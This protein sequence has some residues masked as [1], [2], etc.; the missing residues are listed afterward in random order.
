MEMGNTAEEK[1]SERYPCMRGRI[2]I[3]ARK[4][5]M[6]ERAVIAEALVEGLRADGEHEQNGAPVAQQAHRQLESS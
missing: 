4:H 3:A 1:P 6:R 2:A 5:I